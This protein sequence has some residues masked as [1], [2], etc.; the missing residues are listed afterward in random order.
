ML[1]RQGGADSKME[2][3]CKTL[4]A[5]HVSVDRLELLDQR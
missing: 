4:S 3:C 5:N 2:S 1:N